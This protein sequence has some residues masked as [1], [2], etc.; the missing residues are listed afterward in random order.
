MDVVPHGEMRRFVFTRLL[1][2][3]LDAIQRCGTNVPMPLHRERGDVEWSNPVAV[4][5]RLRL[6]PLVGH[7]RLDR[8]LGASHA[9]TSRSAR[10][11]SGC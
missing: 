6:R 5:G 9:D 2:E 7:R 11:G 3:N 4:T 8:R 10:R 1:T